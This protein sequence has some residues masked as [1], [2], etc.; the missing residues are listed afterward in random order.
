MG[1]FQKIRGWFKK[2]KKEEVKDFGVLKNQATKELEKLKKGKSK[3]K[4]IEKLNRIFRIFIKERYELKRSLT[5]EEL[6]KNIVQ[7]KANEKIKKKI[8]DVASKIYQITYKNEKNK[9]PTNSFESLFK[10]IASIIKG[11]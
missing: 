5:Y 6:N 2:S 8:I 9:K 10:E 3:D 4:S 11:S 7:I 1:L